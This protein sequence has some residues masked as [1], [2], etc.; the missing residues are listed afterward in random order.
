MLWFY[1]EIACTRGS[2]EK[3]FVSQLEAKLLVLT[4]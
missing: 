4:Q 1:I 2:W 3:K